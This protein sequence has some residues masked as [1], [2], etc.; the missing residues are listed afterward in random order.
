[1]M[2]DVSSTF[3]YALMGTMERGFIWGCWNADEADFRGFHF[4]CGKKSGF[5]NHNREST[6]LKT[7]LTANS[8]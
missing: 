6:E 2:R 1:M 3:F 8:Q 7:P 5:R 4:F